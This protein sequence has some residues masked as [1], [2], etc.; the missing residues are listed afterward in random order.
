MRYTSVG[1]CRVY[2]RK[3]K[4]SPLLLS[5]TTTF[6]NMRKFCLKEFMTSI[7]CVKFSCKSHDRPE[8]DWFCYCYTVT[9]FNIILVT[10][11]HYIFTAR[12][13]SLLSCYAQRCTSYRK[14]VRLS[15]CLSVRP[16]V[17]HTLALC[18]NDSSYDHGV[19]TVG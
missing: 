18:Q 15:V 7:F 9:Y 4:F 16:S 11:T 10:C 14:S 6:D 5:T 1:R 19:F 3:H 12:Q 13:H 8:S 2:K 17:R